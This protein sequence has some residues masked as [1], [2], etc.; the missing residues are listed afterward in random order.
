MKKLAA[1][2]C[3]LILLCAAFSASAEVPVSN[4]YKPNM[5]ETLRTLLG[6]KSFT[7]AV[8]GYDSTG[9][10]EDAKFYLTLTICERDRF[11]AAVIENL[12]K[13]DIITFSDGTGAMVM[14]VTSD[15]FGVTVKGGE[16]NVFVFSKEKDGTY[17]ASTDTEN[18]FY[19][20]VFA[21]RVPL[22]KDISFLDWSDPE[23]L[24]APEKKGFDALLDLLLEKTDFEPYN[25]TVTFDQ[26]GKLVE[27]LYNYSPWN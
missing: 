20:E 10:D 21:V 12:A 11:D 18:P 25:T 6:G 15:E 16:D 8:T 22:E 24:E 2:L 5:P 17:I 23:N 4:L 9:E 7:A 26:D 27:F 14:E 13:G 1:I 19:A 3:S